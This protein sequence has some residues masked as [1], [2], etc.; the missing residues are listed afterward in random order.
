MNVPAKFFPPLVRCKGK[1]AALMLWKYS[2][3]S[4]E[5]EHMGRGSCILLAGMLSGVSVEQF[6]SALGSPRPKWGT[7]TER[8]SA[9]EVNFWL[10]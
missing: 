1:G 5:E 10:S 9:V 7:D 8:D 6:A 2:L 4:L 3:H